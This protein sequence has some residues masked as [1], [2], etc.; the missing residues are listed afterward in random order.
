VSDVEDVER[1]VVEA[2]LR[3]DTR[4]ELQERFELGPVTLTHILKRHRAVPN[5]VRAKLDDESKDALILG[6]RELVNYQDRVI[7]RLQR[8]LAAHKRVARSRGRAKA[9]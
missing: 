4:A 1:A 6:L 7:E 9:G 2:F 8:E 3:G 5:R